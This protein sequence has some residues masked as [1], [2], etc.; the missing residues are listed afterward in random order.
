[1]D[2]SPLEQAHALLK[3]KRYDEARVLLKT[4]PEDLTAQRWLAKLNEVYPELEEAQPTP[5]AQTVAPLVPKQAEEPVEDATK[6]KLDAASQLIREKRYSEARILL[7]TIDDPK[8][9]AWLTKLDEVAP[10]SNRT[11]ASYPR[12]KQIRWGLVGAGIVISALILFVVALLFGRNSVTSSALS[13]TSTVAEPTAVVL[14]LL[15]TAFAPIQT[16]TSA[17]TRPLESDFPLAAVTPYGQP[18]ETPVPTSEFGS[19]SL[20]PLPG[21]HDLIFA[22]VPNGPDTDVL[23]PW[24]IARETDP[25][26]D[27]VAVTV[28]RLADSP[29]WNSYRKYFPSLAIRCKQGAIEVYINPV[30]GFEY[31]LTDR[32]SLY[33]VSVRIR[34]DDDPVS[35][36][37][38]A[39][40]QTGNAGF[41]SDPEAVLNQLLSHSRLLLGFEPSQGFP[42]DTTFGLEDLAKALFRSGQTCI[43]L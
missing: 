42:V 35:E 2:R 21:M 4:M 20:P 29:I 23:G 40:S 34:L 10:V 1:M 8:A 41:F 9:A 16:G 19:F 39:R 28:M 27:E 26:T 30:M 25:F 33:T 17:P 32:S 18:T 6:I 36:T 7:S 31:S 43:A 38:L 11:D 13:P 3:A 37:E 5:E 15:L 24:I 14:Q 22:D 12:A